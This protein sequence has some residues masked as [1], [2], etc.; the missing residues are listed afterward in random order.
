MIAQLPKSGLAVLVPVEVRQPLQPVDSLLDVDL[1]DIVHGQRERRGK[2]LHP[3]RHAPW[4][5]QGFALLQ[6]GLHLERLRSTQQLIGAGSAVGP[7]QLV[8]AQTPGLPSAILL[9]LESPPARE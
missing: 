5:K 4:D 2:L 3:V 7:N 6:D 1:V 9:D 8:P